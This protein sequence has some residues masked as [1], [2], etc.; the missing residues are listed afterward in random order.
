M[1]YNLI[2]DFTQEY[3]NILL[4]INIFIIDFKDQ[5]IA[6]ENVEFC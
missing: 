2:F 6:K 3:F 1:Q 4:V 5:Q